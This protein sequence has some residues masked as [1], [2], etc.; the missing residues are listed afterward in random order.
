MID[1][2]EFF[3]A[4]RLKWPE[5]TFQ[6]EVLALAA[7]YGWT[8]RYH[9]YFSDRS[10]RGFPDAVMVRPSTH[11][12]LFVEFKTMRGTLRPSQVGWID[13]LREAE[14]D[15]TVRVCIWRPCCWNSGEIDAVLKR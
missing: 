15:G 1:G 4:E 2:A 10:E 12:I 7:N 8:H 5:K 6:K 13:A 14:G 9:T 11:Q 3:A